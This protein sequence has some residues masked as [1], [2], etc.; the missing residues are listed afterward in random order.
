[1]PLNQ[2]EANTRPELEP[3]VTRNEFRPQN[4]ENVQKFAEFIYISDEDN[5]NSDDERN[6]LSNRSI[7]TQIVDEGNELVDGFAHK[8]QTVCYVHQFDTVFDYALPPLIGPLETIDEED[9][10][11]I[12]GSYDKCT[13]DSGEAISDGRPGSDAS[14]ASDASHCAHDRDGSD[15]RDG[16]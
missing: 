5:D 9:E 4:D 15:G 8:Q 16:N 3:K 12:N 2:L 6:Y 11:L 14:D 1:M 13:D 10:D 7:G